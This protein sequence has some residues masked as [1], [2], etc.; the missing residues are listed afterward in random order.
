MFHN[1]IG[2]DDRDH[3]LG[4]GIN[5]VDM[6]FGIS[7]DHGPLPLFCPGPKVGEPHQMVRIDKRKQDLGCIRCGV[8]LDDES[9]PDDF[10]WEC[11]WETDG[12]AYI[13]DA[14]WRGSLRV[15]DRWINVQYREQDAEDR[16]VW[17]ADLNGIEIGPLR[18]GVG[19]SPSSDDM[20]GTALYF[21]SAWAEALETVNRGGFS[22]NADMFDDNRLRVWV[23]EIG[24]E[25]LAL[26]AEELQN[27][28]FL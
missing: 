5:T 18:S 27:D 28:R 8:T 6:G 14:D 26:A 13:S 25:G 9:L 11:D 1:W 17:D 21:L 2:E 7:S 4:C 3:C 16:E 20:L 24:S 10:V 15:G 19:S 23:E 22:D 12:G